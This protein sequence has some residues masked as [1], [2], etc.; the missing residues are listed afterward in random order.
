M[1]REVTQEELNNVIQLFY[2]NVGK[3]VDMKNE[4]N[5]I[6]E[7]KSNLSRSQREAVIALYDIAK[8]HNLEI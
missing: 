4:Y 5:L 2:K 7:K 8:E 6:Q 3:E 1:K